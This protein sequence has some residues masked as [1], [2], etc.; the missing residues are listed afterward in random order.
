MR[1]KNQTTP[2][3]T[4]PRLAD[5]LH[6]THPARY[7]GGERG[8]VTKD[9]ATIDVTFALAFPDV[10]EVG[11]SHTGSAILYR[12]LNDTP[13][14]AAERAYAPWP[15]REVQLRA[16]GEPLAT[17]ESGRALAAFDLVGFSLQYEL[18]YTNVLAMLDVLHGQG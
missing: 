2:P 18:S 9:W 7:L 1:Q 12:V 6:V 16:N 11:M 3:G 14:I 15:D 8:S 13:W 10:Y 4:P 5:L 17:L